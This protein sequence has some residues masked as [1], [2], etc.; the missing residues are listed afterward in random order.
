MQGYRN[1]EIQIGL[2]ELW[3]HRRHM[4]MSWTIP[5]RH[6]NSSFSSKSV[7]EIDYFS[8]RSGYSPGSRASKNYLP[9]RRVNNLL[10]AR[11]RK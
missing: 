6:E 2:L 11:Q 7:S 4:N 1:F 10:L 3:R 8:D 9:G 5:N